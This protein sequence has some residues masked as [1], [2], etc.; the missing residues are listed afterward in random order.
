MKQVKPTKASASYGF[1]A[2]QKKKRIK[3]EDTKA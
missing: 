2:A 1:I 3:K